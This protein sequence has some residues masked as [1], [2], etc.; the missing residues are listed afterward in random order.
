MPLLNFLTQTDLVFK[1]Q[2]NF[3]AKTRTAKQIVSMILN[4]LSKQY[5]ITKPM[6]HLYFFS[7]PVTPFYV[8]V[9]VVSF[10][11]C[12]LLKKILCLFLNESMSI[13]HNT[14]SGLRC[15][16][17]CKTFKWSFYTVW[18]LSMLLPG[19]IILTLLRG[20]GVGVSQTNENAHKYASKRTRNRRTERMLCEEICKRF[21]HHQTLNFC[22]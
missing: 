5:S 21:H 4:V 20:I 22:Y 17:E 14:S 6:A 15:F 10:V 9:V 7:F 12:K 1:Y 3:A 11:C 13:L 16:M 19:I 18:L 2:H 8:D